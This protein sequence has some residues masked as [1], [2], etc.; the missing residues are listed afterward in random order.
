MLR[1][2]SRSADERTLVV[3]V[4]KTY[5]PELFLKALSSA[6]AAVVD[7][8]EALAHEKDGDLGYVSG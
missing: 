7:K 8:E 5:A 3:K 6:V 1:R 2:K 4:D